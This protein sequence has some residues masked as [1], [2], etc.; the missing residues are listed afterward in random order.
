MQP[1]DELKLD[2]IRSFFR[3]S[4][5]FSWVDLTGGE[6]SLRK[7]F[8]D[9]CEALL[10]NSKS[11]LMLHYPTNGFLTKQVVAYT[12]E[13]AKMRPEKLV[14][15]VSTDGDEATNDRIR[16][17]PGGWR[18]QL[19]TFRQLRE[20]D[21]VEVVLGMTLS[22]EN[23]HHFPDAFAAAKREIPD[24]EVRDFHVNI[25]NEGHLLHNEDL[26]LRKKVDPGELA[27]AVES[28][29]KLRGSGVGPVDYLERSYLKHVPRW[30]ATGQTPMRCHALRSS[31]YVDSWGN[32]FPCTIYGRAIGNLRESEFDLERIWKNEEARRLQREIWDYKCPQC[33]TPC[34]AY[35]SIMGNLLRPGSRSARDRREPAAV[36]GAAAARI[37][38]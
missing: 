9:I 14:I 4:N 5:R 21:G 26:G 6:V 25:V 37:D 17:V 3:R 33:W 18:R 8:V 15:T 32:V 23:V 27:R 35:Q 13:V 1:R 36:E 30:L 24:L 31:C 29:A 20:I 19:E 22:S 10:T 34:E 12:R 11:L 7:D 28:Y 2:E 16:G 38:A